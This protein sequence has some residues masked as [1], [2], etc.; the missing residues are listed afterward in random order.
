MIVFADLH[1]KESTEDICFLVLD[2]ILRQALAD[3]GHVV[4]CG[5]FWQ[6]RYRVNVRLLNRVKAH[7]TA[8]VRQGITIDLV[9]G[10]HDQVTIDGENALEVLASPETKG[11]GACVRVHTVPSVRAGF[12]FC[13]YR[14]NPQEQLDAIKIASKGASLV[15][16]HFAVRGARMNVAKVDQDGIVLPPLSPL[17]IL[18]HY[19]MH[20]VDRTQ[21]L[22][23]VGSPYQQ[24]FGEAGNI[25]GCLRIKNLVWKHVPLT[26]GPKY[27]IARWDISKAE[28]PPKAPPLL[29]GDKLRLDVDVPVSALA[30]PEIL[31]ALKDHGYE[32]ALVNILPRGEVRDHKFDLSAGESLLDAVER[33][34]AERCPDA[35]G[36]KARLAVLKERVLCA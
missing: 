3:D 33:F 16:G 8:W 22:V 7:F 23:Y 1:L 34:V 27:H 29:P 25:P 31:K 10:N 18:G 9:P 24:N 35:E 2:E 12:G 20:Q 19:H 26:V 17:F 5:D 4:F 30:N 11:S 32:A 28:A 14:L 21:G 6:L 36:A 15:F 13:P